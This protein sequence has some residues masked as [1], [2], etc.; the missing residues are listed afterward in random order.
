MVGIATNNIILGIAK[1]LEIAL[2]IY[3]YLIIGRAVISWVNADPGNPIVRFLVRATE[4]VLSRLR[5]WFPALRNAGGLDFTPL[6][7]IAAIIFAQYAVVATL[8]Q[9]VFFLHTP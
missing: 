8:R 4:P 9:V 5:R 7:V 1:V 2:D 6:V 3:L